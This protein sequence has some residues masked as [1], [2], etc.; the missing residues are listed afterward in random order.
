MKVLL[1]GGSG[2]LGSAIQ[3][4]WEQEIFAPDRTECDPCDV[5]AVQ[6]YV[7]KVQPDVIVNCVAYNNVDGAEGEGAPE[8]E[9][10]NIQCPTILAQCAF[11]MNTRL[12]HVSTDYV[13]NGKSDRPYEES[14]ATDPINRYGQTKRDGE[15]AVLNVNPDFQII[16][17]ARLYGANASSMN[18][19]KSFVDI[20]KELVATQTEFSINQCEVGSP[21]WVD[22]LARHLETQVLPS[23]SPRGILHLANEG[24]ATWFEWAC[25]IVKD[26]ESTAIVIPRDPDADSR[27]AMRPAYSVLTSTRIPKMR[28]WQDAL[29][30]FLS[31]NG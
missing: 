18:A 30:E 20:V 17:T 13:F 3:R 21:T 10:L 26:L 2:R 7:A 4:I 24:G 29:R 11:E 5:H 12:I 14:D 8:A 16:R 28:P 27:R 22:D 6:M 25:E 19:K 23:T 1:F 31:T 9:R 15:L